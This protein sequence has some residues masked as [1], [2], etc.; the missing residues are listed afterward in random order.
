MGVSR[1]FLWLVWGEGREERQWGRV[2][3]SRVWGCSLERS[4]GHGARASRGERG[5]ERKGP[6][7]QRVPDAEAASGDT[8]GRPE[9]VGAGDW[10]RL[11][12]ARA[13]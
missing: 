4:G 2:R 3:A 10:A 11:Q 6:T 8:R 13:L 7:V 1:V 5:G 12:C 9:V